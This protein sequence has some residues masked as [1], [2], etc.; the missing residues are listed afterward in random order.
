MYHGGRSQ[1]TA[2]LRWSDREARLRPVRPC[3]QVRL[4]PPPQTSYVGWYGSCS[5][6]RGPSWCPSFSVFT[7]HRG[8]L[9]GRHCRACPVF[10]VRA[11]FYVR[12]CRGHSSC[13][14][15]VLIDRPTVIRCAG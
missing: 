9:P 4:L 15:T 11:A 8:F 13:C 7:H 14:H 12:S 6:S 1:A 10:C 2:A 3:T 5:V